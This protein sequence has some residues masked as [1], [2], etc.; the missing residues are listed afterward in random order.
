LAVAGIHTALGSTESAD[1]FTHLNCIG[2]CCYSVDELD[3]WPA[4][5]AFSCTAVAV[6]SAQLNHSHQFLS[7]ARCWS[8]DAAVARTCA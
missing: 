1:A 3:D 6:D 2:S 7:S 5:V 8:K 4:F